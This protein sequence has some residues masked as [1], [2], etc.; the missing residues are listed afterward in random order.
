MGLSLSL[1]GFRAA[2]AQVS[3][4]GP[5]QV[6]RADDALLLAYSLK[7]DLPNAVDEALHK[8]VP[9]FFVVEARVRRPR[10]YWRDAT[11]ARGERSWRL[12]YQALTRQYRLSSGGQNLSQGYETLAEALAAIRRASAW[13]LEL[14]ED[15]AL[16]ATYELDFS[17]RLDTSLLPGPLQIGLGS[18]AAIGVSQTRR[19]HPMELGL[20]S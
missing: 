5:L 20:A 1:N 18:G 10:W 15:P 19:L 6:S 13:R 16:N 11:L 17:L 12:T 9:L 3:L 14:R 7:L 4:E 2:R 8:G